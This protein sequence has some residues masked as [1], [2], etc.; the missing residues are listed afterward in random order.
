MENEMLRALSVLHLTK[1]EMAEMD[2]VIR[3][4]DYKCGDDGWIPSLKD[5]EEKLIGRYYNKVNELRANTFA[6]PPDKRKINECR[7]EMK[8]LWFFMYWIVETCP[9]MESVAYERLCKF[10]DAKVQVE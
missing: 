6:T 9:D 1:A 5:V 3:D 7:E 10:V 4:M 8:R 2:T